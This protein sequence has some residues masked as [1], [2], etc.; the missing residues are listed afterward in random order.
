MRNPYELPY[1][2]SQSTAIRSG[3]LAKVSG[4][5][6]FSMAFT[7]LGGLVG[8]AAPGLGLPAMIGVLILSFVVGLARNV[9]GLNLILMYTLTLLMGVGLGGIIEAYIAA[10]AGALVVEAAGA[11]G[12]LTLG[13]SLYALT[14]K[15]DLSSWGGKLFIGLLGLIAASVVSIFVQATFL[16]F[17]LGLGG[18]ILFSLYLV[19]QIQ[20]ARFVE[21]T[22]PNAIIVAI[23]IYISV[24]NLFL[25][26]LRLL[27][28]FSGG[29]R[30]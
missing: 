10:G 21:D 20:Q 12:L 6:A 25:S 9:A 3:F 23:G 14:T 26:I 4:L 28:L 27:T 5:L 19:Y 17:V 16:E 11:T 24:I 29:S 15:R 7:V 2:G 30:R 8:M 22:L 18:S 1:Y 13:L